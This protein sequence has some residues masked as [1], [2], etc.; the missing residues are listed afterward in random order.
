MKI[1]HR[2]KYSKKHTGRERIAI[3]LF[4]LTSVIDGLISILSLGFL[5]SDFAF[6]LAF[7]E[8]LDDWVEGRVG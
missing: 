5:G 3:L 2:V 7:S 1:I 6:A 4:G 8:Q